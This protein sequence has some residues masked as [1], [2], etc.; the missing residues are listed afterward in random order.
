MVDAGNE[1]INVIGNLSICGN[2]WYDWS[3][4]AGK[5]V[6]VTGNFGNFGN[7]EKSRNWKFWKR[8]SVFPCRCNW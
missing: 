4:K 7:F 8:I 5:E 1:D 2:L 6:Q 3:V